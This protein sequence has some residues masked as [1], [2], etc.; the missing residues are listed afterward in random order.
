MHWQTD[1]ALVR[2][3]GRTI[4]TYEYVERTGCRKYAKENRESAGLAMTE[5]TI[6]LDGP[7]VRA[8]A[9]AGWRLF[10]GAGWRLFGKWLA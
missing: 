2:S 10:L 4:G 9:L 5:L 7:Y 3:H 6:G 1:N 8:I